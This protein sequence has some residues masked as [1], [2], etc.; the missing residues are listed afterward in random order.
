MH[1]IDYSHGFTGSAHDAL[2]F[3]HTAAHCHPELVFKGDEFAL[4]DSTYTPSY[5]LIPIHKSPAN[6]DPKVASFD[7]ALSK[8][9]V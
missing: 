1:I 2:A 4:A 6:R 8:L 9:R 5:R 7:M 3:E